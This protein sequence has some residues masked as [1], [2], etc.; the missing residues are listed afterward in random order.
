LVRVKTQ[1]LPR[2]NSRLASYASARVCSRDGSLMRSLP[3]WLIESVG[4]PSGNMNRFTRPRGSAPLAPCLL[5]N[6]G[7]LVLIG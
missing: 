3:S 7:N 2:P 4:G 1:M 6:I 5:T